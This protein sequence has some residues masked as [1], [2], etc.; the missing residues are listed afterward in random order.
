PTE[1]ARLA[2]LRDRLIDGL[3]ALD[4]A[5]LTGPRTDRLPHNVHVRFPDV[6]SAALL[7]ALRQEVAASS[8]SACHTG[9]K[10]PSHVLTALGL[11]DEQ[12]AGALRLGLGRDTSE[13][14][15][16]QAIDAIRRAVHEVRRAS[17]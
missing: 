3:L 11:S 2:A 8:G 4:G 5:H 10:G 9:R 6:D 15:V 13:G 16:T 12:A 17:R 14:Q 7:M 1:P